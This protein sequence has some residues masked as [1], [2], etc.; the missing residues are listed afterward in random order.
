VNE[1]HADEALLDRAGELVTRF[2]A[3]P[4]RSYAG[5]KQALNR[6]LYPNMD[7]QLELEAELQHSLAR[8]QDFMEGVGAFVEKRAPA[9]TGA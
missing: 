2:A 3:G 1:V 9:F 5:T 6:M 7:E 8:T 4:T